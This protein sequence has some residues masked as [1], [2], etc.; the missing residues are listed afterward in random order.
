MG[1]T[2]FSFELIKRTKL[3]NMEI[4]SVI[5]LGSQNDYTTNEPNP[6]FANNLYKK[7]GIDH[8]ACIDLAG[9]NGAFQL[10]LSGAIKVDDPYNLVTDFGTSC[11]VVKMVSHTSV[12]F[13]N[14]HINSIYPDNEPAKNDI[15]EGYYNCWLNKFNLCK[16]GGIIISEN[17]LTQNWE[18]H[19]YSYLGENF[20]DELA[21]VSDLEIIE[22]GKEAAMGNT[23][24]GWNIWS[25]LKK[26]GN[27][28]PSFEDFNK[29]PIFR[30]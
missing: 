25:V 5:E 21:K 28:F 27:H 30:Q 6:P 8:Y 2:S 17:P 4:K 10:D 24:D 23:T 3:Q 7:L 14:G 13:H 1:I 16:D 11:H 9:D 22:Q 18:N 26:T 20:Y 29:L 19:G 12:A 15:A